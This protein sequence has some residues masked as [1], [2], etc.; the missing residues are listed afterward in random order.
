MTRPKVLI[1]Q[2]IFD[3]A[4]ALVKK[5]FEVDYNPSDVPLPPPVLIKRLQEKKGAITLLTDQIDETLLSQCPDLKIV[6]NVA[7]GYNNIDVEACTRRGVMVTNT[8]EVL[9]DTTADF[10]WTLILGTAR[11]LVE[12]DTFLRSSRW[13]GWGLMDFLG[14]DVHH[15]VLG[16]CGLGRIGQG[17]AR[18]ARGFEMKILYTD[19]VRAAPSIEEAL[20]AQFAEK[21]VLLAQSDFVTLHVPLTPQT[22]HY[23]STAELELMKPSSILINASRGPVIDEKALVK[24]LQNGT[25]AGAGMDVYEK[26]PQVEPALVGMTNVVLAPHI[27]SASGETRLRMATMAAENMVA[28]LMGRR[29]PNLVNEKVFQG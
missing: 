22:T 11:R 18:R 27:A 8:P 26:E 24:A 5:H 12:A 21:K 17:V 20:G 4:V 15:K 19:A 23:I 10:T 3:E 25:I 16:I 2:K 9:D 13:R 1:T 6:S 7:V 14:H 29:P 28:G